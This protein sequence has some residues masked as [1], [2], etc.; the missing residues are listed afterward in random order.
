MI[1]EGYAALFGVVDLGHDIVR[2][3]AFARSLSQRSEPLPMLI[4]HEQRAQ[5]G[6]WSEVI[7][8]GRGLFVRG[9][10]D[11][12]MPGAARALRLLA[13][14]L[15]GLS[16]GFV[17]QVARARGQGRVIEEIELLEVSMVTHPMQPLARLRQS[18]V[19]VWRQ[20]DRSSA[21]YQLST[22]A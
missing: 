6:V 12:R 17:T 7:E 13:R 19:G 15:D 16:I 11:E 2:S 9:A 22:A 18:P 20:G 4:E 14:G 8:D 1:L 5:A 21:R 10:L 3:G